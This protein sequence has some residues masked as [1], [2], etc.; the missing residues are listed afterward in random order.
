MGEGNDDVRK[1]MLSQY[2][3]VS[4]PSDFRTI[5]GMTK[6]GSFIMSIPSSTSTSPDC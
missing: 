3:E 4:V 5:S 2:V 6:C 1:E